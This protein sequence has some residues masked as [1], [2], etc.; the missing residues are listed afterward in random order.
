[1]DKILITQ[2]RPEIATAILNEQAKLN[3]NGDAY[4]DKDELNNVL[5]F[6]GVKDV[7]TLL[8]PSDS[9]SI[10]TAKQPAAA[11]PTTGNESEVVP[12]D[13]PEKGPEIDM[14]E[15]E[16]I[17]QKNAFNTQGSAAHELSCLTDADLA[18]SSAGT[19]YSAQLE[20]LI[21]AKAAAQRTGKSINDID[22]K[23]T[24]LRTLVEDFLRNNPSTNDYNNNNSIVKQISYGK[25]NEKKA[26]LRHSFQFDGNNAKKINTEDI[27]TPEE[28]V[29]G[30]PSATVGGTNTDAEVNYNIDF[31]T[32]N[33]QTK[34]NWHVRGIISTGSENSD[35]RLAA[36]Y[37]KSYKNGGFINFSSN[38]RQTIENNNN[39]GSYGASF[40]Y[41]NKKLSTGAFGMY[42]S[43][44]QD[45]EQINTFSTQ[46]YGKYSKSMRLAGGIEKN[47]EQ[48]Y[49]YVK[50]S[51][52]G[53]RDFPNSN[54]FI[55]GGV[56]A[57]TGIINIKGYDDKCTNTEI[58][59]NGGIAFKAKDF[60]ADLSTNLTY[61]Q[62]NYN[63]KE[64]PSTCRTYVGAVV[65]NIYT[66]NFD[67]TATVSAIKNTYLYIQD[68][69][70]DKISESPTVTTSIM[71]KIKD[72]LGKNV[73]PV[74]KFNTGN[75]SEA[76]QNL[77]VGVIVSP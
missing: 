41:T 11:T 74:L 54:I 9:N 26:I 28:N 13:V 33:E 63:D 17:N 72:L 27:E 39:V 14:E 43:S 58:K 75:Y 77:G 3:P 30:E 48:S 76:T 45:G 10:F 8:K 24:A 31:K 66:K 70:K 55:N 53:K 40:D 51:A 36:L 6:F 19:P 69:V 5:D 38:I 61:N 25:N 60:G 44:E 16:K 42:N 46:V 59:L 68:G 15:L 35:V 47:D 21:Q 67:I 37:T 57:E 56:S 49:Y 22:N 71:I 34:G 62:V 65:S 12:E 1:M 52:Q 2:F 73:T 29:E 50:G 23:I 64:I 4:I 32:L 7:S 18:L 20:A